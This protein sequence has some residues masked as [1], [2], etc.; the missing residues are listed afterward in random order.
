MPPKAKDLSA[1]ENLA[2]ESG[3]NAAPEEQSNAPV[4]PK[5]R[6]PR[7]VK[8]PDMLVFKLLKEN[9]K[10]DFPHSAPYPPYVSVQEIAIIPW[11]DEKGNK[12]TRMIRYV[13]GHDSIFVDE[14]KDLPKNMVENPQNTLVFSHGYLT[15]NA[16][17]HAKI[18]FLTN[19][20]QNADAKSLPQYTKKKLF[21][22]IDVNKELEK[23]YNTKQAQFEAMSLAMKATYD[24]MVPHAS[25]MGVNLENIEDQTMKDEPAIRFEYLMKA[26]QQPELFKKTF[27]NPVVKVTHYVK[28][29]VQ[30][31]VITLT[32]VR[33]QAH[34]VETDRL[35]TDNIPMD[36]DPIEYLS[37]FAL[38]N[39]GAS[40]KATLENHYA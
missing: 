6:P 25:F 1:L 30:E 11:I 32:R 20:P 18:E 22:M 10:K 8:Q 23:E 33:G 40:L 15:V 4:I 35:I 28:R 26:E 27:N 5:L 12:R 39:A 14:Q 2:N 21:K 38:S 19:H 16:Y 13:A 29:A 9:S 36:Q 17:D 3:D 37:N 34:F 24:E 31:N 7:P